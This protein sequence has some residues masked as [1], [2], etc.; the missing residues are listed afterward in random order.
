MKRVIFPHDLAEDFLAV[1]LRLSDGMVQLTQYLVEAGVDS[2]DVHDLIQ[3]MLEDHRF[4][5]QTLR[6]CIDESQA[7][8]AN[9]RQ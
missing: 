5:A 7:W 9:R 4:Q 1:T 2:V 3:A 8:E 6:A